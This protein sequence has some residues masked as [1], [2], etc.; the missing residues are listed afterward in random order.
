MI[1]ELIHRK[2][3]DGIV[4]R[5]QLSRVDLIQIRCNEFDRLLLK[6]CNKG[7]ISD[8]LLALEMLCRKIEQN[9]LKK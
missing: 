8:K 1:T 5:L 3:Y 7:T 4:I 6:E 2:V 9:N